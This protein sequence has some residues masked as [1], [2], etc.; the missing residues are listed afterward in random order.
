M[1]LKV[2]EPR[3]AEEPWARKA[4]HKQQLLF[5]FSVFNFS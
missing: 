3:A 5:V 2:L 4:K 1:A